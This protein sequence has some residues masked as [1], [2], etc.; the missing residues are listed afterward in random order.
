M[1]LTL[2]S[3]ILLITL[4]VPLSAQRTITYGNNFSNF[5]ASNGAVDTLFFNAS[6]G[7]KITIRVAA[8]AASFGSS[9]PSTA[10]E[11]LPFIADDYPKALAAARAEKKPIFLE[12]WA[13]W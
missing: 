8:S 1:K 7:D 4:L 6:A 11:V 9:L 3:I 13:P 5:L 10:K 12:T 2:I